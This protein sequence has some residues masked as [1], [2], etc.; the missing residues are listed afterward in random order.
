[1]QVLLSSQSDL[2]SDLNKEPIKEPIEESIEYSIQLTIQYNKHVLYLNTQFYQQLDCSVYIK[3]VRFETEEV[4][5][6]STAKRK[7]KHQNRL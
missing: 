2:F 3:L 7:T 5:K 6:V 1:L 4:N